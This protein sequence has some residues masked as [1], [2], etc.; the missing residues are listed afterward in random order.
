MKT[1]SAIPAELVHVAGL[2]DAGAKLKGFFGRA[3]KKG[4]SAAAP[5]APRVTRPDT[6]A[7]PRTSPRVTVPDARRVTLQETGHVPGKGYVTR[8]D[9]ALGQPLRSPSPTGT[10]NAG[11]DAYTAAARRGDPFAA[12][13][14]RPGDPR[15]DPIARRVRPEAMVTTASDNA[16]IFDALRPMLEAAERKHMASVR[17]TP[18]A[19][20][21]NTLF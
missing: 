16:S 10:A 17:S 21:P 7:P 6:V 14:M 9:P 20:D 3:A 8:A 18:T 19:Y 1:Q 5:K 15:W 11:M 12:S 13:L 4:G 2:L